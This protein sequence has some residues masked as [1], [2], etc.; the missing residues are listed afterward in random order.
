MCV[1]YQ[2]PLT[3]VQRRINNCTQPADDTKR[4]LR[5]YQIS[6][7][8]ARTV[9]LLLLFPSNQGVVQLMKTNVFLFFS[10]FF[11]F[12]LK[13]LHVQD[14]ICFAFQKCKNYI[15][16]MAKTV[17]I[18]V[19]LLKCQLKC[20]SSKQQG[21]L[22][23]KQVRFFFFFAIIRTFLGK[24]KKF[25]S[26]FYTVWKYT[27]CDQGKLTALLQL[28]SH[29]IQRRKGEGTNPL[30]KTDKNKMNDVPKQKTA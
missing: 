12:S 17:T 30:Q 28:Y 27:L 4:N 19:T 26:L 14:S 1:K 29:L 2:N 18:L 20:V 3:N 8:D 21:F 7:H 9:R 15:I 16:H 5:S 13:Y 24:K 25:L 23:A 10:P 11:L 6:H 22:M